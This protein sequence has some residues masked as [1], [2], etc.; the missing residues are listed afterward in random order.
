ML[1]CTQDFVIILCL[2]QLIFTLIS[3]QPNVDFDILCDE[4]DDNIMDLPG[5]HFLYAAKDFNLLICLF[6][7]PSYLMFEV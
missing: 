7:R 2:V 5:T 6:D 4:D 3:L 1:R